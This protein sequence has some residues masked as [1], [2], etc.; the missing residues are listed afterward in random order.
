MC[1]YHS[2]QYVA[3]RHN[4][5]AL[6]DSVLTTVVSTLCIVMCVHL[7]QFLALCFKVFQSEKDIQR[8]EDQ[9]YRNTTKFGCHVKVKAEN[10]YVIIEKSTYSSFTEHPTKRLPL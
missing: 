2:V 9:Y 5:Q 4:Q 3:L 10:N 8:E 1:F 6:M 7:D